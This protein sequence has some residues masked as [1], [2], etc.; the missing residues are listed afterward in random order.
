MILITMPIKL[1]VNW[2][3]EKN[4]YIIKRNFIQTIKIPTSQYY[5]PLRVHVQS[6]E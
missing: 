2:M 3:N 4:D 5:N 1:E 6:R